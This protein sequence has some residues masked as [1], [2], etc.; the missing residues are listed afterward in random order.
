M[1]RY[2]FLFLLTLLLPAAGFAQ[3]RVILDTD[4]DSDVDDAG[5]LAMLYNLHDRDVINLLG[6]IV[7]SDDP[8]APTCVSALNA[9]YGKKDLL[10][11]FLE[12][13]DSLK[14]HSRY[15][16][17]LS[18]EYPHALPTWKEAAT[19]TET[20]RKL[21]A[22]SPDNS[23][24]ILTIGHLSSLQKLLQSSA[25]SL[26]ALDGKAL[27]A[28]KV[29]KWYCMGGEFP[30]GKEA[31]FS[32]P[33]PASTPYCLNNWNKEVIFC[34]WEIGQPVVTGDTAFKHKL[35]AGHPV[36]RAYELYN[37]F[38]GR[39]SWDQVTAFLLTDRASRYFTIDNK[40]ICV[41]APDGS[42]RWIPGKEGKQGIV[43]F[44]AGVNMQQLADEVTKLMLDED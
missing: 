10:L 14:N 41:V 30:E 25:D 33:D 29:Q 1:T 7:T 15:T 13:Q 40:G 23:V 5:T 21:L 42:N 34:G 31:N 12:G 4:I 28:A 37:N 6:I 36:S 3:Q 39:A 38:A 20:Y 18:E 44:K 35:P 22:G 11:G 24:T 19:A 32:R 9:W 17:Q 27:I 8:F 43:R 26:S 16:R 2:V